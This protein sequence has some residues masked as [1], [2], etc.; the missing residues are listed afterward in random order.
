M[1]R[2]PGPPGPGTRCAHSP[3]PSHPDESRPPPTQQHT[4]R[5]SLPAA[6]AANSHP[7]RNPKLDRARRTTAPHPRASGLP[8]RASSRSLP[9]SLPQPRA[10]IRGAGLT[11]RRRPHLTDPGLF[12]YGPDLV[13]EREGVR[14]LFP[15]GLE[16]RTLRGRQELAQRARAP[17]GQRRARAWGQHGGR[18]HHRDAGR[19]EHRAG[20]A[21]AAA[22]SARSGTWA[23]AQQLRRQVRLLL[24]TA[25]PRAFSAFLRR[26]LAAT[27]R[28]APPPPRRG[29]KSLLPPRAGSHPAP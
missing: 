13:D 24:A 4:P 26:R 2:S 17:E 20:S 21:T 28:R 16:D 3:H 6:A 8:G 27:P 9:P 7:L 14:E 19:G 15:A 22:S 23:D 11:H 18:L 12:G 29:K 5:A 1:T 10:R 25:A